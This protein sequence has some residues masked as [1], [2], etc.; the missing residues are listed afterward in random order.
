M[1]RKT[2]STRHSGSSLPAS[3]RPP[4][5]SAWFGVRISGST[6]PALSY[7]G[8]DVVDVI[9]LDAYHQPQWDP[10]GAVEAWTYMVTRRYGL[11]WHLE[12][13]RTHRKPMAYPEWGVRTDGFDTYIEH[14]AEWF[15]TSGVLFQTYWD[16]DSSYPGALSGGQYP[17]TGAAFRA[18]FGR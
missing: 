7:P 16:S 10:N 8:D 11:Q 1:G 15:R 13:A 9:G 17:A 6:T 18:A 4:T 3:A 14:M 5:A 2:R 12:F